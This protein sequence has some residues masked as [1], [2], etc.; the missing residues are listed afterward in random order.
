MSRIPIGVDIIEIQR[1]EQAVLKWKNSFLNR[2]Y[3][4]AELEDCHNET[5]SLVARFAAKEG[6]MKALGTGN[7]GIGW[8]EIEILSNADGMPRIQLHGQ[9]YERSEELGVT[10]F[11]VTL[12]HSE[13]YAIAFVIGD[14]V[15]KT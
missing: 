8:K 7:K 1:I 14:V 10:E 3:T 11:S 2:I 15:S 4:E 13:E 6:V 9:A 12:S 5:S